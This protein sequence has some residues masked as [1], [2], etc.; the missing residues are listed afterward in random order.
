MRLIFDSRKK[1]CIDFLKNE[2]EFF[3]LDSNNDYWEVRVN[4]VDCGKTSI[5]SHHLAY[6]F[7]RVPFALKIAMIALQGAVEAILLPIKW[8][9]G[10]VYLGNITVVSR[11]PNDHIAQIHQVL[12]SLR[13]AARA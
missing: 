4:E 1:V 9:Y 8:E 2:T 3:T 13:N 7:A 11:S 6:K 12:T 10:L 5:M